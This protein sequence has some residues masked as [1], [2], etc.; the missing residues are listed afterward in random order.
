[1][2]ERYPSRSIGAGLKPRSLYGRT[3]PSRFPSTV[4]LAVATSASRCS[5]SRAVFCTPTSPARSESFS[6][7]VALTTGFH[8]EGAR[9][10]VRRSES[11]EVASS[12]LASTAVSSRRERVV[13]IVR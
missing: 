2:S 8:A 4:D 9:G 3:G 5:D 10:Y 11:S 6:S 13:R 12:P 1:M 7:T